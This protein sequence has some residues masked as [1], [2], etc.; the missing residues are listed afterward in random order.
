MRCDMLKARVD[1]L[2]ISESGENLTVLSGKKMLD[3]TDAENKEEIE[4]LITRLKEEKTLLDPIVKEQK[5]N[6]IQQAS[7]AVIDTILEFIYK[8]RKRM[9]IQ[10]MHAT[11]KA[12]IFQKIDLCLRECNGERSANHQDALVLNFRQKDYSLV[13]FLFNELLKNDATKFL[14]QV[15]TR[16]GAQHTPPKNKTP[17]RW[18]LGRITENRQEGDPVAASSAGI[19][20]VV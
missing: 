17:Q 1:P 9:H 8:E 4:Q 13:G 3:A 7:L 20:R 12:W 6:E 10:E 5:A 19:S 16:Q 15:L 18:G 2:V 14:L 11:L